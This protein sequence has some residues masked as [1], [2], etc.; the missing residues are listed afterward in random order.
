MNAYRLITRAASGLASLFFAIGASAVFSGV[1][2]AQARAAS[3][4]NYIVFVSQRDGAAELYLMDLNTRQVS[5]LTN[6][7]R[8]HL[9]ASVAAVSGSSRVIVFASRAGSGYELYS[10]KLSSE[11]RSRRPTLVG[12]NRMTVDT[13]DQVSPTVSKDGATMAYQSGNGIEL[14]SILAADSRVAIPIAPGYQDLAPA[15]SPDGSQIAFV[16]NRGGSY[17]IWLY[18]RKGGAI[19]QLTAG[20]NAVGGVNWSA[21][22]K[23]IVFTTTA[24]NSKLSGIALANVGTGAFRVL[25]DSNDFNAALSARGDRLVFTSMRDGN[26][27]LYLL[28]VN[29]GAVQRLTSNMGLDD[30]AVFVSEPQ[31]PMRVVR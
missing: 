31:E 25:T 4:E 9:A 12:L 27:E 29:G 24:T 20:A 30:G 2:L 10:G 23:Q 19:R 5:Q 22:A 17:E 16:S 3:A 11:W 8:G 7:G 6:T 21:D 13:M 28:N 18:S 26:A 15:I 14:M 1:V